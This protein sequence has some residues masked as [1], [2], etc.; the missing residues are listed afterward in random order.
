MLCIP[1]SCQILMNINFLDLFAKKSQISNF[2]KIVSVGGELFNMDERRDK[3][4]DRHDKANSS[5]LQCCKRP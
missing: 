1:Y 4:I 5:F 2:M 3:R